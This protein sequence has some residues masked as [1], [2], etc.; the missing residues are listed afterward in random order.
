[1][2]SE[3]A[4]GMSEVPCGMA[5]VFSEDRGTAAIAENSNESCK[6]NSP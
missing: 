2:V 1:M 6:L 3:G 5:A 4:R